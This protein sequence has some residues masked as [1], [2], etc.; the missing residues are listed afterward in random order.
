MNF[1]HLAKSCY[2]PMREAR[3]LDKSI[4]M[5]IWIIM[6]L[7]LFFTLA[8]TLQAS[9]DAL[10][11]RVSL[12]AKNQ[13]LKQVLKELR[14]QSRYSF[15]YQD[16]DLESVKRI[17][18]K[19]DEQE[20]LEVLPRLFNDLPLT[21]TVNG[22]IISIQEKKDPILPKSKIEMTQYEDPKT[23]DLIIEGRVIDAETKEPLEGVTI[24]YLDFGVMTQTDKFG[25]YRLLIPQ[26]N[27]GNK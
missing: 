26:N 11:Q 6:K 14:K 15:I 21:Y 23:K 27:G 16:K 13:S 5:T 8:L 18:L 17:N 1:N 7:I 2:A 19:V 24:E 12:S 4:S 3:R 25:R 20:I 9:A 10:G 22:R